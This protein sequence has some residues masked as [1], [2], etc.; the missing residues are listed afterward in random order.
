MLWRS[1]A[2]VASLL[3]LLVITLHSFWPALAGP[4]ILD[5]APN[6]EN[7]RHLNEGVSAAS[8]GKYLGSATGNPGRP[9]AMLS[10]MIEDS[11]WPAT[12]RDYKRN[13]L[14]LH[15][16]TG[17]A[18]LWLTLRL[19]RLV[20]AS[21]SVRIWAPLLC[22]AAWLLNP[23]QLSGVMLVVQRMNILSTLF[24]L[25]GLHCY[26]LAL[27]SSRGLP[28]IR[29]L[30]ALASLASFG[31]LA[32]LCKENGVLVFAFAIALNC[33]LI[34][35]ALDT[36]PDRIRWMIHA[37]CAVPLL[38]VAGVIA[39]HW[40]WMVVDYTRRDF[41]LYERLITQPRILFDYLYNILVP[42]LGGQGVIHD[43]YLKSTSLLD[44]PS[45]LLAVV[46]VV[47]LAAF[48]LRYSKHWPL[49]AFAVLWFLAGHL[50]E[51]TAIP[52]EL[53][54]EHRNYLAMVGPLF[55]VSVAAVRASQRSPRTVWLLSILWLGLAGALTRINAQ[56]WGDKHV[57]AQV[58]LA[59][60]PQS[61]RAVQWAGSALLEQ[62]NVAGARRIVLD[63]IGRMPERRE[64]E[65]QLLLLDC[66]THGLDA[67]RWERATELF[68]SLHFSHVATSVFSAFADQLR[69]GKCHDTLDRERLDRLFRALV[70]NPAYLEHGAA[71]SSVHYQMAR[72]YEP[73][74]QLEEI[75][76]HLDRAYQLS[77]FPSIPR[78]QALYLL[79]AGQPER[80]LE[81]LHKSNQTPLP[82][83][84]RELLQIEQT[85]QPLVDAANDMIRN[86]RKSAIP[87]PPPQEA[88]RAD[89]GA[90]MTP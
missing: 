22:A 54:F 23:M 60:H 9:L 75:L 83:I 62:G 65:L 29:A 42:R 58:W 10:F 18:I 4:F 26:L 30:F 64:L 55:A 37:G 15:L 89:P 59:E 57:Q 12:A 80:A 46:A 86:Q 43:D 31:G 1:G 81:Y 39:R 78:E 74:L 5:D 27:L 77:P 76:K 7:L 56:V 36:Y 88:S 71:L 47:G 82:W 13:N 69:S 38:L 61:P 84:K 44:P 32:F 79:A 87:V 20:T 66:T 34:R 45:T 73:G 48:A 35:G 49:V 67:A 85:N 72:T 50:M 52:L 21:A 16:L 19:A 70:R 68:S 41:T 90:G 3:L 17:L 63:A 33:T 8:V 14:L 6:L 25:A 53:Y 2:P 24:M 11:A 28:V 40:H 51:S